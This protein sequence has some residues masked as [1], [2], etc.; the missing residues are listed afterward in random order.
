MFKRGIHIVYA[1]G[2][3][4][5]APLYAVP[6]VP[7][8]TQ[9]SMTSTTTQTITTSETINSMD[10]ATGWTY[11]VTGHGV[12]VEEGTTISPDVISTH[13]NTVDG[14]TSTWTGLDLNSADNQTGGRPKQETISVSRSI[15]A[16]Q[17][18]RLT[19]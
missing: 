10:Y 13:S 19:Q 8:F 2:V 16:D 12:E 9:G 18:V 7:N 14:V 5:A 15:T 6:V 11:S 17:V 3:V 4:S 1:I